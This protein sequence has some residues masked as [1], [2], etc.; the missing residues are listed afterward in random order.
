MRLLAESY[1]SRDQVRCRRRSNSAA[2]FLGCVCSTETVEQQELMLS[3]S[4]RAGL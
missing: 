2:R 4:L 1:T 3:C